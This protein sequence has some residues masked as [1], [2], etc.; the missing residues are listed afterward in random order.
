MTSQDTRI[1][2]F[3]N[4]QTKRNKIEEDHFFGF[5]TSQQKWDDFRQRRDKAVKAYL[6]AI[7]NKK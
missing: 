3:H 6:K 7:N 4:A 1:S 5:Q 2:Q